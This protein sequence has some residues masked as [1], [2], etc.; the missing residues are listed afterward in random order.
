MEANAVGELASLGGGDRAY[1][2][3]FLGDLSRGFAPGEID[4]DMVRRDAVTGGGGTAEIERRIGLLHRR[5]EKRAAFDS[6]MLALVSDGLA[7]HQAAPDV[8]KFVGH[9][10]AFVVTEKQ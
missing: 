6:E 4:V 8:Q 1:F 5:V 10:V 7:C 3:Q 2:C 9:F